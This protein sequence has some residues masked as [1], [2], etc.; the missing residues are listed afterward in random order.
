MEQGIHFFKM[1]AENNAAFEISRRAYN[2]H[3]HEHMIWNLLACIWY[4]VFA[5]DTHLPHNPNPTHCVAYTRQ[6]QFFS[7]QYHE[8]SFLLGF[9]FIRTF[10]R[11]SWNITRVSHKSHYFMALFQS[12]STKDSLATKSQRKHTAVWSL[13]VQNSCHKSLSNPKHGEYSHLTAQLNSIAWNLHSQTA[14]N[15]LSVHLIWWPTQH[16]VILFPLCS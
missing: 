16:F 10:M 5:Y 6:S 2:T 11:S 14:P 9:L 13:I 8:F 15:F 1:P 7:Y 4:A 3:F 12:T